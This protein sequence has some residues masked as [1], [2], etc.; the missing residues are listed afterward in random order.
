MEATTTGAAERGV[1]LFGMSLFRCVLP[2]SSF[3]AM[4]RSPRIIP[5]NSSIAQSS[6]QA[7][8]K[9]NRGPRG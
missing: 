2:Q 9:S 3:C 6:L 7:S 5:V 4:E 1:L 8:S